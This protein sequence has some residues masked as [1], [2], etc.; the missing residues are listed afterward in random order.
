VTETAPSYD[1]LREELTAER[2]LNALMV[3]ENLDRLELAAED[4]DWRVAGMV[5]EQEFTRTGL[6]AISRNC[7]LMAIASPLVKRGVQ[8]RTG[9]IWG[10]GIT[11]QGRAGADADQDVNAVVQDFLDDPGNKRVLASAAARERCERVLATDGNWFVAFFT[12]P[13]TGRVWVRSVP[14]AEIQDKYTDPNDREQDQFFLREWSETVVENGTLPGTLRRRTQTRRV[15]HPAL[16][17]RPAPRDRVPSIN[18]IPVEWDTPILHVAVNRPDGWKW[19]VPDVYAAL[20]WARAYEGFLT[21]WARL[22]KSLSKFAWRLTGDRASKA[23]KAADKI[24]AAGPTYSIDPLSG[25]SQA[26]QASVGGPGVM[27]EA[28]PKA[29]ATIDADSGRPLAAMVAAALGLTVVEL[30]ADPGVTGARAVAETLDKP[31]ILE[32][33]MR[34]QM[35]ADVTAT[36]CQY[37]V[38]AAVEA[39]QGPLKGTVTTDPYSG[40][41][42][43]QLAGDVDATVLVEFPDLNELDPITLVN[44]IVAADGTGKMPPLETLRMLLVALGVEDID[45]VIESVTDEQGNFI[46]PGIEAAAAAVA[47]QRNQKPPPPPQPPAPGDMPAAA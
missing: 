40:R 21:D 25:N 5:L 14:F 19:G 13:K 7:Q 31:T 30:L 26:G 15:F 44:A 18:G 11:I 22:V 4:R 8:I 42:V 41:P 36:I 10:Q 37:V 47:N 1:Q 38:T 24:R 32:M 17:Y 34:Q 35:W 27:L 29:G 33:G 3:E 39:P 28:I 6:S 46:D 16:G 23:Q 43:T 12:D 9:Y 45:E 20:P 2:S